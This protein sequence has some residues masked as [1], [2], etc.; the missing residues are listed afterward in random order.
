MKPIRLIQPIALCILALALASCTGNN[1][2]PADGTFKE[3]LSLTADSVEME[4]IIKP[5]NIYFADPYIIVTNTLASDGFNYAVFNK[6][7][8]YLYSFCPTGQGPSDCLMPTVINNMP[9]GKFMV[10]DH[11]VDKYHE[12]ELSDSGAVETRV[13]SIKSFYPYESL[14]EINNVSDNIFIAKGVTPHRAMRRLIDF[15]TQTVLDSI[16]QTFDLPSIMGKDYFTEFDDCKIVSNGK[17]FACAYFFIDN[18]D[19]GT[20]KDNKMQVTK[21]S[22]D[23]TL[24]DFHPYTDETLTGK[25]KYN[26][27]YNTVY[28]EWLYGSDSRIYASYFGMPWGDISLHSSTIESYTY[29][30]EALSKLHLN[31]PLSSFIVLDNNKIIG[32]NSDRSDS[33]FYTYDIKSE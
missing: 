17:G 27:D 9:H 18:I 16:D 8:A 26:V 1:N 32:L 6:D 12:Y 22:G 2:K 13:F 5:G 25:Y 3:E 23:G 30:G 20:V 11:A 4:A 29:D 28:Y 10:R 19:F 31:I 14:W 21:Q 24:Q 33:H 7:L 15:S